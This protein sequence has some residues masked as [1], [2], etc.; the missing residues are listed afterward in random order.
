MI[1]I[2]MKQTKMKRIVT[3]RVKAI[4]NSKGRT[5]RVYWGL[6]FSTGFELLIKRYKFSY[7]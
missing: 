2:H 5:E 4:D 1:I 3:Q 7:L 6:I